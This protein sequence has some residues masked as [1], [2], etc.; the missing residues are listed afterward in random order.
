V[1]AVSVPR[2]SRMDV[3]VNSFSMTAFRRFLDRKGQ[4]IGI[5]K[6]L[7]LVMCLHAND[8]SQVMKRK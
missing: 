6:G 1:V 4:R 2:Y 3:F 5:N 7:D 8:A